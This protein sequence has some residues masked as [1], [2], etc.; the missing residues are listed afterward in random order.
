[1]PNRVPIDPDKGIPDLVRQLAADSRRLLRDEVQLARLEAADSVHRAGR[2]AVW[3][4]LAFGVTVVTLVALTL[5]LATA[6]GRLANGH[7]WIGA[8]VTAVL[9]VG[10][11]LWLLK[12]GSRSFAQAP[13][14][15][16]AV[17]SGLRMLK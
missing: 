1:M 4:G 17:R 6:I 7:Y 12:L 14:G 9:E 5:F 16:P 15:L 8:L 2:G 11:G 13:Y 10:A 3:L